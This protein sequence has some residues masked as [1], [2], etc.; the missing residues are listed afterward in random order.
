LK[1]FILN[2]GE[3]WTSVLQ[4]MPERLPYLD[5]IHLSGLQEDLGT[6]RVWFAFNRLAE[7]A[8]ECYEDPSFYFQSFKEGLPRKYSGTSIGAHQ[9][10]ICRT[11][12]LNGEKWTI[13]VIYSSSLSGVKKVLA[14]ICEASHLIEHNEDWA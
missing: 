6:T 10:L 5:A 13:V 4:W 2:V 8:D 12:R 7:K 9:A 3:T 1:V 14:M 11:N